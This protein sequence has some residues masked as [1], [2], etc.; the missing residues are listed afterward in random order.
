M[1]AGF[2]LAVLLCWFVPLWFGLWWVVCNMADDP[3]WR[4]TP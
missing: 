2:V 3:D 1:T 4:E